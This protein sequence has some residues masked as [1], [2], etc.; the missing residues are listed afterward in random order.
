MKIG[1]YNLNESIMIIA[2]I[3]NN[4]EGNFSLAE[5]IIG[6]AAE[7]GANAVK[8]QTII[9]EKLVSVKETKRI[10]QLRGF[11]FSYTEFERL[12]LIAKNHGLIFLSTPFDIG[13]AKFLNNCVP[14]FKIA[15]GDNDFYPL[16]KISIGNA[17]DSCRR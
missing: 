4:H 8:F 17:H 3:G 1:N 14:A 5:K 16:L 12:S 11:Q 6:L 13:S 10:E 7:S 15:S 2:E 9:P